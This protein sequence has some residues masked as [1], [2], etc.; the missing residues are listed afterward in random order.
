MP[1]AR[2][3]R[4]PVSERGSADGPIVVS[5]SVSRSLRGSSLQASGRGDSGN[6]CASHFGATSVDRH[7]HLHRIKIVEISGSPSPNDTER[8]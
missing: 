3:A 5:G 1:Y 7:L 6:V 8:H 4:H 2:Q